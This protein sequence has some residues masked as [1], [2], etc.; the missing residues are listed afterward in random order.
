MRDKRILLITDSLGFPHPPAVCYEDTYMSKLEECGNLWILGGGGITL[1]NDYDRIKDIC[2]VYEDKFFDI[3][4]IQLGLV[5]C[6]PRPLPQNARNLVAGLP[7]FAV[8]IV[9][10]L[11]HL[12]R[13][14]MLKVKYYQHTPPELFAKKFEELLS[15]VQRVC[16][17]VFVIGIAPVKK[18]VE[19]HSPDLQKQ[20]TSYNGIIGGLSGR[21]GTWFIDVAELI[22]DENRFLTDDA[23]ITKDTHEIIWAKLRQAGIK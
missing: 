12:F 3:G 10:V 13:P 2:S 18:S 9:S 14:L 15:E 16:R 19:R 1:S 6:A 11:L 20:I 23:H 5:D 21:N 17:N 22:K 4:V 8:K 7:K